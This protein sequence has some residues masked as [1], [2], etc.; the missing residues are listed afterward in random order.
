[1]IALLIIGFVLMNYGFYLMH[2]RNQWTKQSVLAYAV[3]I[4]LGLCTHPIVGFMLT[5]CSPLIIYLTTKDEE[6]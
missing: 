1:M 4:F 5:T 6:L 2:T 3:L